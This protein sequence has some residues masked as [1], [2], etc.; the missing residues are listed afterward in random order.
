MADKDYYKILGVDRNA[1][2]DDIKRAYKTLAKKYHPDLNKEKDAE[3]KFKEVNEAATILGDDEKRKQYDQYGEEGLKS[4]GFQGSPGFNGFDFSG[5]FDFEDVF[6]MFF[7]GGGG[8]KRERRGSDLSTEIEITLAEAATGKE[9]TITL[10]KKTR[11]HE[12]HDTG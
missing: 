7:G 2:R 10:K 3:Q 4:G 6:D 8:R 11:C 5:D 12:C 9:E 1:T